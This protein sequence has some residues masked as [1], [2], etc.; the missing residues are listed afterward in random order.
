MT[1]NTSNEVEDKKSLSPHKM[2]LI[3]SLLA[4]L[5][6]IISFVSSSLF[7]N[8]NMSNAQLQTSWKNFQVNN[9]AKIK[10]I[11]EVQQQYS[12]QIND[13]R[14]SV[15][16]F[17]TQNLHSSMSR[18]LYAASYLIHTA[19]LSLQATGSARAAIHALS[20]A[21][22]QIAHIK[23]NDLLNLQQALATDLSRLKQ[24]QNNFQPTLIV[25]SLESLNKAIQALTPYKTPPPLTALSPNS[26]KNTK[27]I[28]SKPSNH[29]YT[30]IQSF[31]EA[32]K[33]LI[34][35]RRQ[36]HPVYSILSQSQITILKENLS[37]KIALAQWAII[38]RN[39]TLF[40]TSL[41]N[42]KKT[43]TS[44][45]PTTPDT[46]AIVQS[47]GTLLSKNIRPKGSIT[48]LSP[49]RIDAL[50]LTK[51]KETTRTKRG[52]PSS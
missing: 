42:I 45:F 6:A 40:H 39:N 13:L 32:F 10:S 1:E 22:T 15:T 20:A 12:S 41:N 35:I 28:E 4:L 8:N 11:Q 5:I 2:T 17:A 7:R 30:P 9:L 47:L 27:K 43:L 16:E 38:D 14:A 3:F 37:L 18:D 46:T 26:T 51:Q 44:R 23:S 49:T 29:W 19:A 25:N 31:L 50:L 36:N 33:G 52:T 34:I 48:L 21:K 24:V